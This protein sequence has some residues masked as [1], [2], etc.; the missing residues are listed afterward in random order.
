M[1]NDNRVLDLYLE[2][3]PRRGI[4]KQVWRKDLQCDR[5]FQWEILGV[6]DDAHASSAELTL[7][8]VVPELCA[9]RELA[10][11]KTP[12]SSAMPIR[13]VRTSRMVAPTRSKPRT[14]ATPEMRCWPEILPPLASSSLL[15]ARSISSGGISSMS[16]NVRRSSRSGPRTTL[17]SCPGNQMKS[18]RSSA[19]LRRTAILMA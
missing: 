18:P 10:H 14:L 16:R 17:S 11:S 2:A 4:I 3:C 7:D 5:P 6:V 1:L 19:A 13:S 15:S 12:A 9:D 8:Q